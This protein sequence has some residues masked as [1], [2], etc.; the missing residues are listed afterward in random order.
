MRIT[1]S[2]FI[3]NVLAPALIVAAPMFG[4]SQD[5]PLRSKLT[6]DQ[7]REFETTHPYAKSCLDEVYAPRSGSTMSQDTRNALDTCVTRELVSE[8]QRLRQI[9]G[10]R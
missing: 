10:V 7:Q 8:Q 4:A 3:R 9:W 1:A 5:V 2:N 6:V